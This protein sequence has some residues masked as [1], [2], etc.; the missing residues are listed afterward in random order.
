MRKKKKK[1]KKEKGERL[2]RAAINK[3]EFR[4]NILQ[5][6]LTERWLVLPEKEREKYRKEEERKRRLEKKEGKENL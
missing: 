1:G 4:E 3:E 5:R 6:K 2:K